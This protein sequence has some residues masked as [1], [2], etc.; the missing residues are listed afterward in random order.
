M[1]VSQWA[2]FYSISP[3][4][5]TNY[6]DCLSP[7]GCRIGLLLDAHNLSSF[8][9]GPPGALRW[10]KGPP[11]VAR[12]FIAGLETVLSRRDCRS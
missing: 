1:K 6:C 8:Q 4:L 5:K 11:I 9:D 7:V 2:V 12:Q 3:V 10:L